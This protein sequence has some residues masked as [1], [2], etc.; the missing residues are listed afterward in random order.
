MTGA[1]WRGGAATLLG[2]TPYARGPAARV[3][4]PPIARAKR[5]Q[6]RQGRER[7]LAVVLTRRGN[8]KGDPNPVRSVPI[9]QGLGAS[10]AV[11][12]PSSGVRLRQR[13]TRRE[14]PGRLKRGRRRRATPHPLD[15]LRAA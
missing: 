7:V 9:A 6:H 1:T 13:P 11:I 8:V 15:A 5:G 10:A 3:G 2:I 14:E 12:D 4:A